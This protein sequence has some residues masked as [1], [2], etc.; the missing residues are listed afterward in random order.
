MRSRTRSWSAAAALA[1][2]ATVATAIPAP[3]VTS[4]DSPLL[5]TSRGNARFYAN[6][7]KIVV[8][9]A[10]TDG[11]TPLAQA[12]YFGGSASDSTK[13]ASV[14]AP[15]S[16]ASNPCTT[17]SKNIPE[18]RTVKITLDFVAPGKDTILGDAG[19]GIS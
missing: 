3:A 6:G 12:W 19:W 4:V 16:T 8:C 10:K 2:A 9:D 17:Y 5:A 15:S 14:K 11:Y 7:D 18:G 13:F 1:V